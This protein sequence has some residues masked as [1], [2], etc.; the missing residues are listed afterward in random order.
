MAR[1]PLRGNKSL[2][3]RPGRRR[4]RSLTLI[5]CEGET[6]RLYFEAAKRHHRLTT[7]EVLVA[8][9]TKGSAPIS[10]VECAER[11]SREA[12]GFD[13]IFCVFDRDDHESFD[14]ARAKIQALADRKT[15]PLPI[16]EA[17]SIP[18]FEVWVLLH[19][20]RTDAP[21]SD[22][23]QVLAQVRHHLPHY[24]KTDTTIG[25]ALMSRTDQA[26]ANA[27]WL[28]RRAAGTFQN[29]YTG[30]HPVLEHFSA[31]AAEQSLVSV[32]GPSA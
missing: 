28:A 27:H 14:R 9:N 26:L 10:V 25:P 12:G 7:T 32:Q 16:K 17:I 2:R 23:A 29:P 8:Q 15:K 6:E 22:C 13:H 31:I 5:V 4:P 21:F 24:A 20:E 30:V 18:C 11:K 1:V 19:Y 3:R